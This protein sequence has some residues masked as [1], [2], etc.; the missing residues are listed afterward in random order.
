MFARYKLPH[1]RSAQDAI[2]FNESTI[3]T[4]KAE[5]EFTLPAD[6]AGIELPR[7]NS[8]YQGKPYRYAYGIH[9][10]TK[11]WFADSIIKVDTEQE[12]WKIWTPETRHLPSEPV[13]VR[14][15]GATREDDGVLLLVAMDSEEKK[16]SLVVLDAETMTEVARAKMP[17]VMGYGFHGVSGR[18]G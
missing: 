18:G 11:G 1:P 2:G 5:L 4:K 13:F 12:D 6:R 17:I 8:V 15:P 7:I 9:L 3:A 16:S 10:E 14:R